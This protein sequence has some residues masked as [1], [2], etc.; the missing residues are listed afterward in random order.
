MAKPWKIPNFDP[1]ESLPVCLEKILRTR[2]HETFSNERGVL[3]DADSE[4][5]HDMRV[6]ARRLKAIMKVFRQ[7]FPKKKFR[8]Q[9]EWIGNLVRSLG[10]VRDCDVFIDLLEEQKLSIPPPGQRSIDLLIAR[11]KTLRNRQR[12]ALQ[13]YFR[14][15]RARHTEQEFFHFLLK[16]GR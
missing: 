14:T 16:A 6:S 13:N 2:Y 9:Y 1:R 8:P 10:A 4:A 11:Q 15:L 12:R 3:E 7:T 5:L